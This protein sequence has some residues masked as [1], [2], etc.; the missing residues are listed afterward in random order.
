METPPAEQP[1]EF[2]IEDILPAYEVHLLGGSS[3][4]GKTTF[5]FQTIGDWQEG[6]PVLGHESNPRPYVYVSIDRSR[7][8]VHRTLTRL[9]L[10][11]KITRMICREDL[12]GG[13]GLGAV[14][15]TARQAYPDVE[16][17][18]IE[19][20]QTLVGDKGNSYTPVAALLSATTAFCAEQ[21]ITIVGICHA[22]KLKIEEGFQHPRELIMGS[23]AWGAYSDTVITMELNEKT[24]I[25][26]VNI[27][28]RNARKET[29]EFVFGEN[30]VLVPVTGKVANLLSKVILS[31]AIDSYIRR[32]EILDWA[33]GM[34]I[35]ERS[36]ER[37]IADLS[38]Q[39]Y[40]TS[41]LTRGTYKRSNP[42][43][44]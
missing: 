5:L 41:T 8:S 40:L 22:P 34:G 9:G 18:F 20:F 4:A 16:V 6:K 3:G 44:H 37:V 12:P 27:M 30:G 32:A 43:I 29:H 13:C 35:S 31:Q 39:G 11:G 7:T 17:F 24:E 19:G 36:A 42:T 21:K 23:T 15:K 38:K 14:V 1:P 10:Q 2:L 25:I 33:N 26:S 28:P